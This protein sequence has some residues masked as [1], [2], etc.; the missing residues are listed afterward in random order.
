[1]AMGL[2][3]RSRATL[4][5]LLPALALAGPAVAGPV[6]SAIAVGGNEQAIE[7]EVTASEPVGYAVAEAAD[8]FTL[9]LLLGDATLGFGSEQRRFDGGG[10]VELHADTVTRDDRRLA[11]LRFVFSREAPYTVS[12]DGAR[13]RVRVEL[14]A[15]PPV[16]IGGPVDTVGGPGPPAAAPPPATAAIPEPSAPAGAPAHVRA[17]RPAS[18]TGTARV[19]VELDGAAEVRTSTLDKPDRVVV[20]LEVARFPDKERTIPVGDGLLRR[21]RVSQHTKTVVRIVCDLGRA[22]AFWVEAGPSGLIVH[23]GGGVR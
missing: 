1:M 16:T 9:T 11:R 15:P 3:H 22:A 5:A 6:V 4:L 10:L 17:I 23:L 2:G 20:D 18:D 21:V 13:V 12:R 14:P 7:V 19:V 8:P